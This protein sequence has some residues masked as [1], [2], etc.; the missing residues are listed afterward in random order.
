MAAAPPT[1]VN[2][3]CLHVILSDKHE[4]LTTRLHT[5]ASLKFAQ[6]SHHAQVCFVLVVEV[7]L[8][9]RH[10]FPLFSHQPSVIYTPN[11]LWRLS[12]RVCSLKCSR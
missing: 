2:Y 12:Y 4:P 10:S 7:S 9:S 8:V 6:G 11:D 5:V 1:F 3:P